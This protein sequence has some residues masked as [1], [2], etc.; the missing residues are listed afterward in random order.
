MVIF[1]FFFYDTATPQ[2]YPL[3]LPHPLPQTRL[4]LMCHGCRRPTETFCYVVLSGHRPKMAS[5]NLDRFL[6]ANLTR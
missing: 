6:P 3:S 5:L 1:F 2:I 4:R